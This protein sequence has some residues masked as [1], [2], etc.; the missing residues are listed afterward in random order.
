MVNQIHALIAETLM[1][2]LPVAQVGATLLPKQ[3]PKESPI[4]TLPNV[5]INEMI[6][7]LEAIADQGGVADIFEL[8]HN[9]GKDF[10]RT[11]YLVKGS[12][13][14]E[15]VDTPKQ[16][17]VLTELGRHFVAG[18]INM[19]KRM[20][21]ELFG[22]LRIV[23]MTSNLLRKVDSLRLPI[24]ALT[25]RVGEWLPNENPLQIVEAIVSWG[26]FAEFFGYND[27]TKEVYLDVGQDNT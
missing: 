20:L 3:M 19:R 18:D 26:R 2:D 14:L 8:A 12:E 23:Q 25:E 22:A 6:G 11:L 5:Q 15:L 9:T 1:P 4:E 7:L 13:L 17:V 10:G 16:Q 24:E 21:H 27:D